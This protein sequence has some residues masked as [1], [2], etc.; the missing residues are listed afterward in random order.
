[1]ENIW[2]SNTGCIYIYIYVWCVFVFIYVDFILYIYGCRVFLM[3]WINHYQEL[4]GVHL[5][6][7]WP[8]W[9][10]F[11]IY[12]LCLIIII[13]SEVWTIT[14]C[15]GLGNETMVC[16]V[17]LSI[18]LMQP[19]SHTLQEIQLC[20][21]PPLAY[22]N[23]NAFLGLGA[24]ETLP[25]TLTML[26]KMPPLFNSSC[27][28]ER[29]DFNDNLISNS[30]VIVTDAFCKLKYLSLASNRLTSVPDLRHI[31]LSLTF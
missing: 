3:S 23:P 24:L 15:L 7:I 10:R 13:K 26:R 27:S 8:V 28:L 19:I 16:A 30:G 29:L 18:F 4:T 31:V 17:C 2:W 20:G 6:L 1:M 25:I 9:A 12:I 22:I 11:N 14:H 21:P 5:S